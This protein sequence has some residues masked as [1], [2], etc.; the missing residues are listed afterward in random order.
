M[1]LCIAV[2][3][4]LAAAGGLMFRAAADLGD[5]ARERF[6][7]ELATD[8]L[9]VEAALFDAVT[10]LEV[11]AHQPG[12]ERLDDESARLVIAAA[13]TRAVDGSSC[14]ESLDYVTAAGLVAVSSDDGRVGR[15][16]SLSESLQERFEAGERCAIHC[17]PGVVFV[18]VPVESGA[19]LLGVLQAEI[20]GAA[21]IARK[22]G[23]WCAILD[24]SGR[25]VGERGEAP[26]AIASV[27]SGPTEDGE[28]DGLV[29]ASLTLETA[30]EL[31]A[32]RLRV[33]AARSALSLL[34]PSRSVK[35]RMAWIGA[36]VAL[37]LLLGVF[38]SLRFAGASEARL[39]AIDHELQEQ[40]AEH[41]RTVD[42]LGA[43]SERARAANKATI[44]LLDSLSRG[45]RAP[46][47]DI[48]GHA[49]LLLETELDA[50]Q[51]VLAQA[52][53]GSARS[54]AALPGRIVEFTQNDAGSVYFEHVDC[55][56]MELVENAVELV[57]QPADGKS[58]EI[59]TTLRDC[60][61]THVRCD[62]GRVRR[63]LVS[64]LANSIEFTTSGEITLHAYVESEEGARAYVRFEVSDTG[65]GVPEKRMAKLAEIQTLVEHLGGQMQ[66]DDGI[67]IG[68]VMWFVLPFERMPGRSAEDPSQ[69]GCLAGLRVLLVEDGAGARSML[70][71]WLGEWGCVV[72][73]IE[74]TDLALKLLADPA[75][76]GR[77]YDVALI[78]YQLEG[79][80]GAKVLR[81]IRKS[82]RLCSMPVVAMT[83][84]ARLAA[85]E[86]LSSPAGRSLSKPLRRSQILATLTS[87]ASVARSKGDGRAEP[88]PAAR[89][90]TKTRQGMQHGSLN[91]SYPPVLI[92]EDNEANQR[93]ADRIVRKLGF[94]TVIV[95]DG[96]RAV[97][98]A[99]REAFSLILMDV[100]M[101]VMDGIE[102][103]RR[104]RT[105]ERGTDRHI[106]ILTLTANA[107][108][109]DKE[110]CLS[111]GAD[112]HIPKP[113][114]RKQLES[115]IL[116]WAE[117]SYRR[118]A[119]RRAAAA[120]PEP[121]LDLA[122]EPARELEPEAIDDLPAPLPADEEPVE[123]RA[124]EPGRTEVKD[125]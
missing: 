120:E 77:T 108:P 45:L 89:K 10:D 37:T 62:P 121:E 40:V 13:L 83:S 84:P 114:D 29:V 70:E 44:E 48:L 51:I 57:A 9:R 100:M 87:I 111:A 7:L 43:E 21:L 116:R 68:S 78:D 69:P 92:A 23:G 18:T 75:V 122:P 67:G 54:I 6:R 102:A 22:G 123:E 124:E 125:S 46:A 59:C 117:W 118:D 20:P 2:G 76:S 55:N 39:A 94:E 41:Y 107:M 110:R 66:I 17:D 65:I 90:S 106:P 1:V 27:E 96:A 63:I 88:L 52:M 104:I 8:G 5:A 12:F 11:L 97:E 30:S 79:D 33:T 101:P 81:R 86:S 24:A 26:A 105:L 34:G 60:V 113:V 64:A 36:A 115:E 93:L 31:S 35:L 50:R 49:D 56:L 119:A 73:A 16:R 42:A 61:P 95:P 32:E 103:T 58:L 80:G 72:Q 85:L 74:G 82:R 15:G 47:N 99:S 3:G 53:Q 4:I 25:I 109:D 14:I 112:V 38:A 98:A 91:G 71:H 28:L 19:G